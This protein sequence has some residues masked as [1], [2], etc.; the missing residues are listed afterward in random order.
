MEYLASLSGERFKMFQEKDAAGLSLLIRMSSAEKILDYQVEMLR[1]N[2][3]P[4]YLSPEKKLKDNVWELTYRPSCPTTLLSYLQKTTL[5]RNELLEIFEDLLK[6]LLESTNYFLYEQCFLLDLSFIYINPDTLDIM[7]VY[8][9]LALEGDVNGGF[10]NM[11]MNL[12]DV[13][14]V[15]EQDKHFMIQKQI[16]E[17]LENDGFCLTGLVQWIKEIKYAAGSW[18][19]ERTVFPEKPFQ[20]EPVKEPEAVGQKPQDESRF[21]T[22]EMKRKIPIFLL[23]QLVLL[24]VLAAFSWLKLFD[25]LSGSSSLGLFLIVAAVDVLLLRKLFA[26]NVLPGGTNTGVNGLNITGEKLL[27]DAA[28]QDIRQ[29]LLKDI[30]TQK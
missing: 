23:L 22:P 26:G 16:K 1:R 28:A 19:K 29:M 4:H 5:R 12:L 17:Y 20:L 2:P 14:Q 7:L 10:R 27:P 18:K 30:K 24:L 11:L 21:L 25:G 6:A 15:H 3:N 9:P 8:L 13:V